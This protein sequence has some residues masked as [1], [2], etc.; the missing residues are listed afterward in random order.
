MRHARVVR[1]TTTPRSSP[2]STPTGGSMRSG[3]STRSRPTATS[4]GRSRSGCGRGEVE[5]GELRRDRAAVEPD[6]LPADE[7]VAKLE[8]VDHAERDAASV[9]RDPEE[10]AGHGAR[11]EVLDRARVVAVVRA[12]G[13]RRLGLDV[14]GEELVEAACPVDAV[15]HPGGGPDHV[16]LD[17][18]G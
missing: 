5:R 18:V 13:I 16:V 17:V 1:C 12:R 15:R 4:S 14:R 2:G 7:A 9:A 10:L 11:P 6:V 8:H 3:W